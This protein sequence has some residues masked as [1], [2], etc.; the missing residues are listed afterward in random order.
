VVV[1]LCFVQED[2]GAS[3]MAHGIT[4]RHMHAA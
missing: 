4:R 2:A 1:F 3:P